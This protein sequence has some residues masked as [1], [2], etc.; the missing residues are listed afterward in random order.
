M[1]TETVTKTKTKTKVQV[2][3]PVDYKVIYMNDDVTTMEFVIQTLINFFGH[4]EGTAE[5]I[6][7][8]IHADGSAVVAVLPYELAEQKGVEVSLFAKANGFPLHIKL[9]PAT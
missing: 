2:K 9:E 8:K 4:S 5:D 6:T 1:T 3:P 7:H